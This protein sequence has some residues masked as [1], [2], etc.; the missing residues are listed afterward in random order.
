MSEGY[1]KFLCE[2]VSGVP[3]P[4]IGF[5][6]INLLRT[7]L[8]DMG[9]IG[10][11]EGVGFGNI[12]VRLGDYVLITGSRTG[13]VRIADIKDYALILD[14]D[15]RRFWVRSL[16]MVP[17][18]SESFTHLS[19]YSARPGVMMVVHLHWPSLWTWARNRLPGTPA[20]AEFG[21]VEL[22][23]EVFKLVVELNRDWG[24]IGMWGHQDGLLFWARDYM[25]V[26]RLLEAFSKMIT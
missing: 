4:P 12:S 16:G 22:A 5:D 3:I 14:W 1:V 7:K 8:W 13:K 21:S 26:W 6:S 2:Q 19:V 10:E 15:L 9:V 17:A 20:W 11:R 24:V 18:S 25:S 23:N